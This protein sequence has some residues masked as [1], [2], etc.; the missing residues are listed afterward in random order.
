MPTRPVWIAS[1]ALTL[2]FAP[3]AARAGGPFVPPPPPGSLDARV[4]DVLNRAASSDAEFNQRRQELFFA[5]TPQE[6]DSLLRAAAPDEV[7]AAGTNASTAPVFVFQNLRDR[8]Y[9]LREGETPMW[10]NRSGFGLAMSGAAFD[11]VPGAGGDDLSRLGLFL[12]GIGSFGNADRSNE[13]VGYDFHGA[14]L[15][16]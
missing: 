5:A 3:I 6:Q 2:V 7:P 10:A 15:S 9:A 1:L 12:N 8:L 4:F 14:G 16:A 11:V 13:E